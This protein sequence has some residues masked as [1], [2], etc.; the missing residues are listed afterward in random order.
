MD[1]F[2]QKIEKYVFGENARAL[3]NS[4]LNNR[5][6]C[7][8][9]GIV[10][11]DWTII[12]HGVPQGTVLGPLVFILDVNDFGEE[13]G[14]SSNVLQIAVDTAILC[15]EKNEQC[16]N[17]KAKNVLME[18]EQ[19]M[20][21]NKL[22]LNEGKTE[23]MVFKNEKLP[24]VNCIE[25]KS[26]SLKPIDESRYLGVVLDKELSYQK[27]LNNVISKM[28]SAIRSIY[29]LR[30]QMPL[31]ARINLFGSLVLSHLDSSAI[32]FQSLP[33]NSID[34]INKQIL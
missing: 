30:N 24:T 23:I 22:T 8:R 20:K 6:Q 15:H 29:L 5:K 7:V 19:Y 33:S 3:L 11:S 14:K 1:I 12:N 18:T 13:M 34:R 21:Q 9:N 10:E 17:A 4:F 16:L 32:F 27:Q 31:R 28:A 2:I 25:L 26:H